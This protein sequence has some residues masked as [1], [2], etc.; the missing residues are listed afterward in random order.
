MTTIDKGANPGE[1]QPIGIEPFKEFSWLPENLQTPDRI[2]LGRAKD[3]LDGT[4]TAMKL[5]EVAE[6]EDDRASGAYLNLY[7][8]GNLERLAMASCELL[9]EAI[10]RHFDYIRKGAKGGEQ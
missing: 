3:I 9:R 7:H 2:L 1:D 5:I 6:L 4:I 8:R 10:D